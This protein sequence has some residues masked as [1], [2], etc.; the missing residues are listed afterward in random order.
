MSRI[1]LKID[2][3]KNRNYKLLVY[4]SKKAEDINTI[5]KVQKLQPVLIINEAEID[6]PEDYYIVYDDADNIEGVTYLGPTPC[7]LPITE[8]QTDLTDLKINNYTYQNILRLTP[9]DRTYIG[10]MYY[11]SVIGVNETN[12]TITH[13]S[14]QRGVL[15]YCDFKRG[16]RLVYSCEDS[17]NP[18]WV[19][20][21]SASWDLETIEIGSKSS[22]SKIYGIPVVEKV[23]TF[24]SDEI[25]IDIKNIPIY[26]TSL[27]AFPNVWQRNNDRFNYRKLKSYRIQNVFE[28]QYGDFSESTY[29]S[30][31]PVSIEKIVIL[32]KDITDFDFIPSCVAINDTQCEHYEIIRKN[33]IYYNEERHKYYGINKYTIPVEESVGIFNECSVQDKIKMDIY[34]E[35]N[36][37]YL[38]TFYI[39]DVYEHVSEPIVYKLLT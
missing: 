32:R 16:H 29:Q 26:N 33:G 12:Q 17:E 6:T 18:K 19:S 37:T 8:Y 22:I 27:L 2:K 3:S 38:Y 20:V 25:S 11:Y 24:K 21:G 5:S 28:G 9:L 31:V 30:K 13:L 23:P 10:N 1:R 4:R 34:T 15:H 7:S 39:Y 14:R 35:F 36:K